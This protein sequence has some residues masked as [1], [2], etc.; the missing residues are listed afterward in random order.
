MAP[1]KPFSFEPMLC[2][3]VESP[4]EGHEGVAA[5]QALAALTGS[6]VYEAN[7]YTRSV[8]GS[9]SKR[10]GRLVKKMEW[11]CGFPHWL[12][13]TSLVYIFG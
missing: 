1:T 4:P 12:Q 13:L 11:I 8:K 10:D 5:C 9:L 2:E 6:C 7:A 3:A